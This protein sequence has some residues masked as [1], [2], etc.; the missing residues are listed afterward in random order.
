MTLRTERFGAEIKSA[1]LNFKEIAETALFSARSLL[2][3]WLPGGRWE[4]EEYVAKNPTRADEHPGSF[5]INARS[6]VWSDFATG[7][8]GRDLLD[9]KAFL[10]GSSLSEAALR[11]AEELG[12]E[13]RFPQRG[14][15]LETYAT[16][17]HLPLEFLQSLGLE[18]VQNPYR[19]SQQAVSIPYRRPDGSLLRLRYRVAGQGSPKL[20]WDK[21]QGHSVSLYGLDR[22]KE[23]GDPLFLV[24]GESD[25]HTLWF[26]G[27]AA[28][29]APG[30]ATFRPA[31]DDVFLEGRR[32]IALVEPDQG[33][34]ALL[35]RL[36][37]SS[38]KDRIAAARLAGFKDVSELH[39]HDPERFDEILGAAVEGA[40]PLAQVHAVQEARPRRRRASADEDDKEPT[41]ADR[42][43]G[44]AES[45][46][47]L[48]K[49]PLGVAHAVIRAPH[50]EVWP[51]RSRGFKDWL[52]FRY[53]EDTGRAPNTEALSVATAAIEALAKFKGE[54][55]PVFLRTASLGS[56]L[57]VD[58][59]D[60]TWRA[61]EI[62][63]GG[64]RVVA[65][66][67]VFFVRAR[68]MLALPEPER[69]GSIS[70]LKALLNLSREDDFKLIVGWLL[71]ALR[72]AGPYPLL[73]LTGEAGSAK[74]TAAKTLRRLIDPNA[75]ALR[76]APKDERDLFIAASNAACLIYDN[77]SSIPPWL[78]DALCRVATGGGFATRALHTDS[79]EALFEVARPV[80]LTSVG[81]VIARSDLADRTIFMALGS[82]ADTDRVPDEVFARRLEGAAPRVLAA[83]LDGLAHGL[84]ATDKP[85][86]SRLP[87][88]ASFIA[89]TSACE[90]AF[91]QEG[92]IQEAFHRNAMEAVDSVLEGDAVLVSLLAL[93][94]KSGGVWSGRCVT[95][96]ENLAAFA[97]DGA[98]R[99]R[100]WPKNP[101]TLSSRIM[102]AAPAPRKKGIRIEKTRDATARI[103][104]ILSERQ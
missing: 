93:L 8:A 90:G 45:E 48:F 86:P 55:A 16:L 80:C 84:A 5:K 43:M 63:G 104:T 19:P 57:Y 21:A 47:T 102:L 37:Q 83:L 40:E 13:P 87:R 53:F 42:L 2:P 54:T 22:L 85:M 31:R 60:E 1:P 72:P 92:A 91:W 3:H 95:L 15:S 65:E 77:L 68:G 71:S 7:D 69:G 76:S 9:L 51:V 14:I 27:R 33:G 20:I 44:F 89:W 17:K 29:G 50:R 30:A 56:R 41:Q 67:P 82:I 61:V 18:T 39:I 100:N 38:H 34:E 99:E 28:L 64:W 97:P 23:G 36:M 79:E 101:Q 46:S 24:E 73:A 49:T 96:L 78:S 58:L 59:C 26:R 32:M 52:L 70:E 11:L 62:H 74:S 81:D 4:G 10:D 35:Q 75:S 6:G 98:R 25:C 12:I 66:P 103:M 88:L 94:E